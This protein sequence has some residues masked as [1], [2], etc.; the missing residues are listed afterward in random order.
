[1]M[2]RREVITLLGGAAA[3][4]PIAAGAQSG[5]GPL[6]GALMNISENDPSAP[7]FMAAFR[8]QLEELGWIDGRSTRIAV[9][10]AGVAARYRDYAA[11]LA[12][13]VPTV[14]LASTT[15]AV[16]AMRGAAPDVPIV[17]V[18]AVDP[19]GSGLVASLPRPG[20]NATGFTVYEYAIAAKWLEL[21]KEAAPGITRVAVVRDPAVAAGIG[22]FAAIQTVAPLGIELSVIGPQETGAFEQTIE[23][24]GR[25]PNGGMIVT[26]SQFAANHAALIVETAQRQRL[27]VVTPFRYFTTAGG[28]I[29]YGPDVVEPYRRA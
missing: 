28:L 15:P 11:E 24:F 9:R 7:V 22:Q 18:N 27:P 14:V 26:A 29:S 12:A 4:R 17:F 2:R 25:E 8:Q 6:I 10:W 16:T 5:S 3:A 1:M 20:G 21:L 19:V 23:G 13:L